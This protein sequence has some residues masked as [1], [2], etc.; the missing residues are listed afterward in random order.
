MVFSTPDALV[1]PHF[2][3]QVLS[4]LKAGQAMDIII[5]ELV[6]TNILLAIIAILILWP[7]IRPN[8]AK[9]RDKHEK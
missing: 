9:K 3:G 1:I 8:P 7:A 4:A 5:W 2:A 6:C